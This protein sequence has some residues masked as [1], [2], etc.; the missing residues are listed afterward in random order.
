M[1]S[2]VGFPRFRSSN[3]TQSTQLRRTSMKTSHH[4]GREG[5]RLV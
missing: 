5:N 3:D 4:V 1:A 2:M